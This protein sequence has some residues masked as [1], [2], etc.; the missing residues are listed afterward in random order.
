MHVLYADLIF[1]EARIMAK[2]FFEQI[3]KMRAMKFFKNALNILN[4]AK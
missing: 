2:M 3:A 1:L 4:M